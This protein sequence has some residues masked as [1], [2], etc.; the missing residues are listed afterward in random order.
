MKNIFLN[1]IAVLVVLF[2][3]CIGYSAIATH[4]LPLLTLISFCALV[5]LVLSIPITWA[6]TYSGKN[7]LAKKIVEV[8]DSASKNMP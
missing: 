5:S 4:D 1:W 8:V 2:I 7:K 6:F 3:I